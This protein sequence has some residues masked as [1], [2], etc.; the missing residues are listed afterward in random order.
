MAGIGFI[1][2]KLAQRDDFAGSLVGYFYAAI[3]S[4]GPWLFTVISLAIL[5]LIGN[6]FLVV[7]QMAEF[8]IIVVYNFAFSLVFSAP[9]FMVATRCLA[10]MIYTRDVSAAPGLLLGMIIFLFGLILPL[11]VVFYFFYTDLDVWVR[12]AAVVNFLLITGIWM[13]SI[14]MSALKEYASIARIFGIGM[15]VS[16]FGSVIL[17]ADFLVVGMLMGFNLGLA[18]IFF[19]LIARVFAEYPGNTRKPFTFLRYFRTHWEI[20]LSGFIYNL[21]VW[22]D[23]WIMWFSPESVAQDNGMISYPHY[24]GAMFLAYLSIV[25]AIALFTVN[26]ETRFFEQYLRF[27]QDIQSHAIYERIQRNVQVLW[28]TVLDSARNIL[29]LQLTI[30]VA[31]I[32]IAP[33]LLKWFQSSPM[34][35]GIF[36]YGVLGAIFHSFTMFLMII[37]SYFDVRLK[38]LAVSTV[39]LLAN[40][41]LTWFSMKMGMPWYG[42]GYAVASI[43]SFS[44]AYVMVANHIKRLPYETFVV[45][46]TSID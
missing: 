10:D 40:S 1:L 33:E 12:L 14:F 7:E 37:L 2:R 44:V 5:V 23:K 27:Y 45:R 36:R 32:L 43:L 3:I 20:A 21:G 18:F 30:G 15:L 24:D 17:S 19:A 4:S 35:L 8:R 13:I 11:I 46:N 6:Q 31:L 34:Q 25:P 9:V 38:V 39:F 22:V 28:E 41:I 16:L 29:V 26:V 42:W